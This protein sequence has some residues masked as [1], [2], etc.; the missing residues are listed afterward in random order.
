MRI[1]QYACN[2]GH[3]NWE[4]VQWVYTSH[5]ISLHMRRFRWLSQVLG[6]YPTTRLGEREAG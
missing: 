6:L 3:G 2:A 5:R 4:M 1:I